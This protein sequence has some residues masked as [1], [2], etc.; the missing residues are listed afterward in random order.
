MLFSEV[1]VETERSSR[2]WISSADN[3]TT[4]PRSRR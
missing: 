4:I 1:R 2:T 3:S